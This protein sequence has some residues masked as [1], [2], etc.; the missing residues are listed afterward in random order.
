MKKKP[1]RRRIEKLAA[2][3][4]GVVLLG[5]F[6][7]SQIP[8]APPAKS[9]E[10]GGAP[11]KVRV[12][13]V[14]GGKIPAFS[15]GVGTV[16]SRRQTEIASRILAEV[17]QVLK[18][19]GD[20]VGAGDVLVLLDSR[21]LQA[22]I[23]QAEANLEAQQEALAEAKTEHARMKNLHAK[24][25]ATQQQLDRA[26][27]GLAQARAE[28]EA[29][30]KALDEARIQLGYATIAAPFD[31]IVHQ[32]NIDPGDLAVPGKPL[33]GI[34][35]PGQLRLE[36]LVE[37][38]ILTHLEVKDEI[39][40]HVDALEGAL[41]GVVSEVVPA[42]DPFTRTGTVKID[43][44]PAAGLRPGMFGRAR[45]PV[46]EREA[47]FVPE[48]ALVR[49][50][51]LEIVFAVEKDGDAARAALRL[52]RAGAIL[53]AAEG[54]GRRIEILSGLAPGEEIVVEWARSLRD[55]APLEPDRAP[56]PELE[57]SAGSQR[58][59]GDG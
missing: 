2:A 43:L 14:G 6:L 13:P 21:D 37:E 30:A 24:D 52:V 34:Y 8:H 48:S 18:Q 4:T 23:E 17:K 39:E 32:K 47:V 40:V 50:G 49:R 56:A 45:I 55:G 44:E 58:E 26:T 10:T 12:A 42:V 22:R 41:Q 35:D 5:A 36:A 53:P 57:K 46:S 25:A 20:A 7:I 19:P 3:G 33:L 31:G 29:A 11:A 1:R 16:R 59:E 28:R 27:F 54:Q 38:R 51:Q 15:A 9:G